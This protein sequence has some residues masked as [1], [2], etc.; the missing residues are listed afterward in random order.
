M[1]KKMSSRRK[2]RS[3]YDLIDEYMEEVESMGE[4]LPTERP[5]WNVATRTIEPLCNVSVTP[6]EV[7]ITADLPFSDPDS[8]KV[9]PIDEKT[10]EISAKIRRRMC[11]EDL[12]ITHH[13]GEFSTFNCQLRIPV[14]VDAKKKEVKFK[15]GVLEV[16]LPRKKDH[17]MKVE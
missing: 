1:D 2:R 12:G 15:K 4:M 8:I 7:I 11:C 10:L 14:H 13:K 6:N 17:A 9:E 3:I 16:R 5:S